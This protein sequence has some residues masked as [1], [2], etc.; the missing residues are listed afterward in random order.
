MEEMGHHFVFIV[1]AITQLNALIKFQY[2]ISK[3]EFYCIQINQT[4]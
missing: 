3:S 4:I 2:N 1:V